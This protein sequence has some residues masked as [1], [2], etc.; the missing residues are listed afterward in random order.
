MNHGPIGLQPIA[1]PLSYIPLCAPGNRTRVARTGILH[2][3][4]TPAVLISET[5][6]FICHKL[7]ARL[8][9]IIMENYLGDTRI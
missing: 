5:I 4:T 7:Y 3:T 2:Y 1:L 8:D 9:K 6:R